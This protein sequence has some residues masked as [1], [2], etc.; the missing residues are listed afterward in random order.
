MEFVAKEDKAKYRSFP[1]CTNVQLRNLQF[2]NQSLHL[3]A[4]LPKCDTWEDLFIFGVFLLKPS[5]HGRHCIGLVTQE[6][7][8][9][10]TGWGKRLSVGSSSYSDP[11]RS[12]SG[13]RQVTPY[14]HSHFRSCESCDERQIHSEVN[15]S[16]GCAKFNTRKSGQLSLQLHFFP[17]SG[18]VSHDLLKGINSPN[19][20]KFIINIFYPISFPC[21]ITT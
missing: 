2:W 14:P 9:A 20:I 7:H 5:M 17:F 18:V 11:H 6:K 13:V 21:G 8:R 4:L 10:Q 15:K 16:V 1:S 3:I 19:D 12:G